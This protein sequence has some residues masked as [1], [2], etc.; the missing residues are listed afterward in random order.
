MFRV[1]SLI[2][3]TSLALTTYASP[4]TLEQIEIA[5]KKKGANWQVDKSWVWELP[6]GGRKN[7]LGSEPQKV[8][9]FTFIGDGISIQSAGIDQMLDW[10][11]I[12]GLNYM[13]PV[14]NQGKCGSCV[15]FASIATLEGQVN[16]SNSLPNLNLDF[17]E[18][19]IWA[20]GSGKCSQGWWLGAAARFLKNVG[21]PDESCF[22]Y[23]SGAAG[24]DLECKK[25]CDDSDQRLLKIDN[26][27]ALGSSSTSTLEIMEALQQGP[28]M[29]RMTVYADFVAYKGGVYEH[30]T[31]DYLGGHAITIVGYNNIEKYWIVKNSWG[32]E[33]G[34]KGYF[35]IKMDD[36]SGVGAGSYKFYVDSFNGTGKIVAPK[37]REVISGQ[38]RIEMD[39]SVENSVAVELL[40]V[41][42]SKEFKYN[43]TKRDRS[44]FIDL[45]TSTLEDGVYLAKMLIK[46]K[47]GDYIIT[48]YSQQRRIFVLNGEPEIKVKLTNLADGQE[49]KDRIYLDLTIKSSP[50]PLEKLVFYMKDGSGKITEV[51]NKNVAPRILLGWRTYLSRNGEYEVWAQG[52]IG[53]HSA[54]T[55][56]YKVIIKNDKT[57]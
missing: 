7:M 25:S 53:K 16:V 44:Y 39:N 23:T 18:Q 17:S 55:A 36:D 27:K 1:I 20:C 46:Y 29:G 6:A 10:R 35:R 48:K 43:A 32:E 9:Q 2:F 57:D 47:R 13:S 40:L 34:E 45:N 31:G 3:A 11:D 19:H 54:S 28:L 22:P 50:V 38:Y 49:V 26:Y 30:V 52:H 14:T 21:V 8:Q 24:D 42:G 56:H 15:A 4:L 33:W 5:I 12:G 51:V 37:V 41:K